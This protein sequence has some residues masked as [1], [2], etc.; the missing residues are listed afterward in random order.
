M[1]VVVG[2]HTSRINNDP[3]PQP[4]PTRG[5]EQTEFAARVDF[6]RTEASLAHAAPTSSSSA[7]SSGRAAIRTAAAPAAV[8]G[9][10][11]W[12]ERQ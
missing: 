3:P 7:A 11:T 12:R 8:S 5:R 9:A 10:A 1:G 2:R 4:S 6:T